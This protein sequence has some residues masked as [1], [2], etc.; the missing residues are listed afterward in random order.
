MAFTKRRR[1]DHHTL[2][3]NGLGGELPVLD[4]G[5]HGGDRKAAK[6]KAVRDQG[7]RLLL[8]HGTGSRV[9]RHRLD[10]IY[11]S[12]RLL[13]LRSFFKGFPIFPTVNRHL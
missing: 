2:A 12:G 7:L 8:G 6:L 1:P 13:S 10:V 9:F 3:H 4:R 5:L 11:K